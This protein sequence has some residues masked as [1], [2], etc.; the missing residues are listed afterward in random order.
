ELTG[1]NW[2]PDEVSDSMALISVPASGGNATMLAR[3]GGALGPHFTRD[4]Q[5]VYLHTISYFDGRSVKRSTEPGGGLISV[6]LD[7]SDRREHVRIIGKGRDDDGPEP[8]PAQDIRLSPDGR[9]ALARLHHQLFLI[10][11]PP[12]TP[13]AT[14][15]VKQ[16]PGVKQVSQIGAD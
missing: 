12:A 6:A 5:R 13:L 15:H 11:M 4:G 14:V 2:L 1:I 3:L 16:T 8:D 9:F 10:P 7:G